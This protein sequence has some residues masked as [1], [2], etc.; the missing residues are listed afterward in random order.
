M[1]KQTQR[2]ALVERRNQLQAQIE[3]DKYALKEVNNELFA[4]AL[5]EDDESFSVGNQDVRIVRG[6][7]TEY[8][9]KGI[10][11]AVGEKYSLVLRPSKEALEEAVGR[12]DIPLSVIAKN[13]KQKPREPYVRTYNN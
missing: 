4:L 2:E 12:G 3:A 7:S 10:E 9:W 5:A 1:G 8:D 6:F 11:E 13:S